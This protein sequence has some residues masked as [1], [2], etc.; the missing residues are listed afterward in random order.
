MQQ[1]TWDAEIIEGHVQKTGVKSATLSPPEEGIV[2]VLGGDCEVL[3]QLLSVLTHAKTPD[4]FQGIKYIFV[5]H[6]SKSAARV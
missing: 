5:L 3:F 6:E 4:G 1:H 2:S